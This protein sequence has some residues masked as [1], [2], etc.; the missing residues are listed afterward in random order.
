MAETA[1][2]GQKEGTQKP[3]RRKGN[4]WQKADR[5]DSRKEKPATKPGKAVNPREGNKTSARVGSKSG[6]LL[7]QGEGG[8]RKRTTCKQLDKFKEAYAARGGSAKNPR[9]QNDTKKNSGQ[10]AEN[11][12]YRPEKKSNT[13]RRAEGKKGRDK[14]G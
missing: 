6:T 8:M 5:D 10:G 2:K 7:S 13:A 3:H 12:I 14:K 11:G 4:S 9:N 1:E